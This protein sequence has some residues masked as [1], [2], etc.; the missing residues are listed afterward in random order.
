M[1]F[2]HEKRVKL[3]V[4]IFKWFR[5]RDIIKKLDTN[6]SNIDRENKQ[7]SENVLIFN[8]FFVVCFY[9]NG[10]EFRTFMK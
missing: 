10:M 9:D 7:V 5:M 6:R 4:M 8:K 3:A 1:K 2:D